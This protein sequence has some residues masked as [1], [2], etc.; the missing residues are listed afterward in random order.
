MPPAHHLPDADE[1]GRKYAEA[2]ADLAWKAGA[3]K[4][5]IVAIPSDFP[6]AW[7]LADSPPPGWDQASLRKLLD[8]VAAVAAV[9]AVESP[10]R[11][12]RAI[13]APPAPSL[14]G[15]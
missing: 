15:K 4:A 3:E 9:A 8:A 12:A 5:V 6:S 10:L 14:L 11:S 13:L 2:V 1:P 7:D